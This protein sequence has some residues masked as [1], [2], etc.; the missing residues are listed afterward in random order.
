MVPA[1]AA[2]E[3]SPLLRCPHQA[4]L[5]RDRNRNNSLQVTADFMS[6]GT[7]ATE[8]WKNPALETTTSGVRK[9]SELSL[10]LTVA[11]LWMLAS[12]RKFQ[13]SFLC[14]RGH[15]AGTSIQLPQ[16]SH[17]HPTHQEGTLTPLLAVTQKSERR[18]L[19]QSVFLAHYRS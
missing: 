2:Q 16:S 3:R 19:A 18:L 17:L 7:Q 5:A 12:Y 8:H 4:G 6:L 14:T 10:P 1:A 13:T 9:P 11:S 15:G